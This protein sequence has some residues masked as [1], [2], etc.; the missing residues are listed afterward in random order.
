MTSRFQPRHQTQTGVLFPLFV[1]YS[2]LRAEVLGAAACYLR[3]L[4]ISS[5]VQI[6][7]AFISRSERNSR[8]FE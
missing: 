4:P 7:S 1:C 6:A 2:I 3:L 8:R 5:L